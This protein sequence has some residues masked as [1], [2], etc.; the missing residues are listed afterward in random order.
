[1]RAG[2]HLERHTN[3][4]SAWIRAAVLGADDA[5]VSTTSLM[6]GMAAGE[7]SNATV[8]LAGAAGLVAGAL[9]MAAGEYV[10]VSSQ[11]DVE[12]A[13]IAIERREL[14]AQPVG[15]MNELI[16]IYE[17][18]GLSRELAQQVAHALSAHDLLGAHLR[19][20]LGIIPEGRARPLLA[21]TS[22]AVS[23]ALFGMLPL[24]SL[25]LAP[26]AFR[27]PVMAGASLA[28]LSVLG[29]IGA[30][31][32]GAP[33]ARASLRVAIGG[34]LAMAITAL[35]GRLFGIAVS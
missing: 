35:V 11:K 14:A 33:I 8:F 29:A 34:A 23:F 20:E 28:S 22:S 1:M 10:S 27:I 19:D 32:G 3:D 2:A 7:A 30:K 24:A 12:D 6:I 9:S 26:L 18:R 16:G 15:E 13:Q 4:R 17:K 25:A 21:A 5:I 31:L